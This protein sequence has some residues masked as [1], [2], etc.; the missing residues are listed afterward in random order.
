MILLFYELVSRP[1][2]NKDDIWDSLLCHSGRICD[3][4]GLGVMGRALS[5]GANCLP[6][7]KSESEL[8]V[9]KAIREKL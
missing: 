9:L 3:L 6:K 5:F 2:P 7:P 4:G 8:T 1:A